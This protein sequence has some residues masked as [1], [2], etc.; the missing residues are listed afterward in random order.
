[1]PSEVL[2]PPLFVRPGVGWMGA[3]AIVY[4][5]TWIRIGMTIDRHFPSKGPWDFSEYR[6]S[7]SDDWH[8]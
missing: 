8:V 5:W 7:T 4:G 6:N 1:M 2:K 3:D